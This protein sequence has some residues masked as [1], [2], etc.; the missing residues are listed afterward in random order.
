[1]SAKNIQSS[2]PHFTVITCVALMVQ[3]S[4]IVVSNRQTARHVISHYAA[5]RT[6]V[7][8]CK[9]ADETKLR[10]HTASGLVVHLQ[11]GQMIIQN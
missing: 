3:G 9:I 2:S 6:G 10:F 7:A 8:H 11:L 4:T 1:M 5:T